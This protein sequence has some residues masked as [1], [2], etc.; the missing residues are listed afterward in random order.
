MLRRRFSLTTLGNWTEQN[1]QPRFHSAQLPIVTSW[2]CLKILATEKNWALVA[3]RFISFAMGPLCGRSSSGE[4]NPA[5]AYRVILGAARTS[6]FSH[7]SLILKRAEQTENYSQ[8]CAPVRG[9]DVH[10][11]CTSS[12][13]GRHPGG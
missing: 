6:P 4:Y 1:T 11:Q 7:R 2:R 12:P 8:Q 9:C 10:N 3:H 13:W 5:H